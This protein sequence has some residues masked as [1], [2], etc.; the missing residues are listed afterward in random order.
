MRKVTSHDIE[1][2]RRA[3]VAALGTKHEEHYRQLL[4][5][6]VEQAKAQ[7]DSKAMRRA[8]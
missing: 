3:Y 4:W 1:S 5:M 8:A 2:A 7:R 6:V